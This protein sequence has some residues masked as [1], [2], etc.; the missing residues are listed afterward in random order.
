VLIHGKLVEPPIIEAKCPFGVGLWAGLKDSEELVDRKPI[1]GVRLGTT[2][3]I[4]WDTEDQLA[5]LRRNES[6]GRV[7]ER[8]HGGSHIG[9]RGE[10]KPKSLTDIQPVAGQV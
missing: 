1:K 6:K 5:V 9:E 7:D 3:G 2:V 8:R 10:C 4:P